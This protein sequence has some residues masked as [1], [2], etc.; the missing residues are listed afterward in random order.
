MWSRCMKGNTPGYV[1][2]R[3]RCIVISALCRCSLNNRVAAPL[4][5]SLKSP[6]TIGRA[7]NAAR[8]ELPRLFRPLG[9]RCPQ[10]NGKEIHRVPLRQLQQHPQTLARLPARHRDVVRLMACGQESRVNSIAVRLAS[11]EPRSSE[12]KGN[13]DSLAN[14]FGLGEQNFLNCQN[15]CFQPG[16]HV[17]DA[18]RADSP[19]QPLA[20]VHVVSA[21][22][23]TDHSWR[24]SSEKSLSARRK[25]FFSCHSLYFTSLLCDRSRSKSSAIRR[26]TTGSITARF[27]SSLIEND[28]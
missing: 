18:G 24:S 28:R 27:T 9:E 17:R 1:L 7:Q 3:F 26:V 13:S 21:R 11:V 22:P 23:E 20:L 2:L 8:E 14:L 10:M 16:N 6:A 19:I 25:R 5:H 4:V 15:I 12:G